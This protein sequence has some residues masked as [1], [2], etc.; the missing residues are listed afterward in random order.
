MKNSIKIAFVA[1]LAVAGMTACTS[2]PAPEQNSAPAKST[3]TTA[4]STPSSAAPPPAQVVTEV[5]TATVTN[6]PQAVVKVDNRLGY[7]E[8]KLGMTLE[9]AR[10]AGLTDLSWGDPSENGCVSDGKVAISQR[11]GV[12]RITLPATATTSKGIGVGSTFA[13]V[14]KAYPNA[15]EY[16][17][18]WSARVGDNAAYAFMG[19]FALARFADTDKVTRIKIVATTVHCAMA[20][21]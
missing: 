3:T 10:A 13:E 1:A 5:V 19:D 14:K 16:R 8:L 12:E 4:T 20:Y 18:G 7:G 17:A 21:L 9:E 11:Y 2:A 6:P 15:S